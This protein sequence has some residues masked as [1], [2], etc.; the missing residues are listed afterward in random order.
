M[1]IEQEAY[2]FSFEADKCQSCGGR[3]CT[4]RSGYVFASI[5][6][7][8]EIAAFLALSFES[9]CMQ[10]VRKVGYKFS[11]LEKSHHSGLACVFLNE[12]KCSIYAHRPAQCRYFP[13]WEA[14]K[15]LNESE[16][17]LL[18][19]ECPGIVKKEQK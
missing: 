11:F 17:A 16:F 10:Y 19:E 8:Q 4:G 18:Q 2:P 5:K 13:F 9:F 15:N 1:K 7:M 12:G 6:E 14:H 3:C